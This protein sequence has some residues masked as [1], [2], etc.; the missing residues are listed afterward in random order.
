M[1]LGIPLAVWLGI[2]T[3]FS[4]A[5]TAS[6]GVAFHV[7]HKNVFKYHRIFA[8]TTIGIA[9]FHA[10]VAFLLWFFGVML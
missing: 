3:F 10:I 8:F 4:L 6:L 9:T 2:L 1:I 7:F 5:T